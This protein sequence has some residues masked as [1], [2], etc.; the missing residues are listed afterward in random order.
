MS[1]CF[2][3]PG[4]RNG[5]GDGPRRKTRENFKTSEEQMHSSLEDG[6]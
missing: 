1:L 5:E 4:D 3:L 6:G 2:I